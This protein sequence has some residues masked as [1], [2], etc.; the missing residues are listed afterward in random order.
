VRILIIGG[1]RFMGPF[2][3]RQLVESGHE[4]TVFHRGQTET[5]LLPLVKHIHA[6]RRMI[7]HHL[8]ELRA[9]KPDA[10]IDMAALSQDDS[11]TAVS[12]LRGV[13]RRY[14]AI[15]SMDVYA[16]FARLHGKEDG[17]PL[18]TPWTEDTPLRTARFMQRELAKGPDDPYWKYDKV[19]MEQAATS[20]PNLPATV[21]RLP[22]VYGLG[23]RLHRLHPYLKR[24]DDGRPTILLAE[25]LAT[26]R[27]TRGYVENV[28]HA[29]RLAT[30]DERATGRIYNVGEA[31][32]LTEAEWVHAIAQ[33]A[34]WRGRTVRLPRSQ[35][36]IGVG[37][38]YDPRHESPLLHHWDASSARARQEL[39]YHELISRDEALRRSVAWERTNPPAQVHPAQFD[40]AAED[41][42]LAS[43][44]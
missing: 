33:A 3:V 39:G 40:Y 26:W 27:W 14:V 17:P 28:A 10:V 11:A 25:E 1:T 2:I 9:F 44:Q 7:L 21:L 18:P 36:P 4:V 13:A 5:E 31:K 30:V 16:G 43:A 20:A 6:E 12:A 15:S 19:L 34:G 22:A 41:A 29:I 24:M 32:A 23:D 8:G 35:L 42:V 38:P 37:N